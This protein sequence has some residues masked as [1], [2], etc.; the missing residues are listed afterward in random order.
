MKIVILDAAT[1]TLNND[2]DFSVFNQFGEVTIYQHT[3]DEEIAERIKEADVVLCNKSLMTEEKMCGAKNL[4]YIGLFATG[5]NNIDFEYTRKNGITVCNAGSYSTEAVAQHVFA[6]ILH[7][8]NTV[9]KYND[10]VQNEGWIHTD[11]FSPFM[12]MKE[13][14]GKTIGI[15]GYGSIGKKVAQIANAFDMKVLAYSRSMENSE[16]LRVKSEERGEKR[17]VWGVEYAT[18]DRILA[19]SDIVTMHC[20]LNKDSEKMCNKDF[21]E[22]MKSDALFINTSRGGV[23]D[24]NALIWA[25]E[26]DVI[27][28]A[29][30][31]VI[32]KEPMQSDCKLLKVKNLTI[33]PHAAWGPL[34]TRTRLVKIVTKNLQKWVAKT[35]INVIE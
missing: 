28:A 25:L 33:T 2:I 35:P 18:V 13:L 5:Y 23:V 10:F 8:C 27:G 32:D 9:A 4:K 1:L 30:L 19:E 3:S 34:E 16:D 6:F 24:E 20:P 31:D 21:F 22:K 29:A 11:R 17:A 14:Y 12:E 7:N 15:I 26:N